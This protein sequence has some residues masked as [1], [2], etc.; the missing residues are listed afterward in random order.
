MGVINQLLV[1]GSMS[2][3]RQFCIKIVIIVLYIL[4]YFNVIRFQ[5]LGKN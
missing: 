3:M 4:I 1:I 5:T 2:L